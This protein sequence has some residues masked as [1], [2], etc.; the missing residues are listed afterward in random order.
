MNPE[1]QDSHT[2]EVQCFVRDLR[3]Y[4]NPKSVKVILDIGSSNARESITIK[5]F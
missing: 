4:I 2:V 1:A 5:A 3:G